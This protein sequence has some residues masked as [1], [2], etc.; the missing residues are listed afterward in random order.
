AAVEQRA[1]RA[2]ARAER[3]AQ[4]AHDRLVAAELLVAR[5]DAMTA[6]QRRDAANRAARRRRR[7]LIALVAALALVGVLAAT[8]ALPWG[9]VAA[10]VVLLV[11]W[12]VACRVMVRRETGISGPLA[13]IPVVTTTEAEQAAE[14]D[15]EV[16]ARTT[17]DPETGEVAVVRVQGDQVVVD[18][19]PG[20]INPDGTW[21]PVREHVPGYV[22]QPVAQR[23]VSELDLESTGVW[24][25][26]RTETDAA[27]AREAEEAERARRQGYEG[28]GGHGRALGS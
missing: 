17:V 12:L 4:R 23:S 18:V 3:R 9:W 5:R 7:V 15:E 10:P 19:E 22:G 2:E 26:G 21:N 13:R 8:P 25:S 27:I 16:V 20:S 14:E 1:A 11:A 28:Q 24:T 6:S